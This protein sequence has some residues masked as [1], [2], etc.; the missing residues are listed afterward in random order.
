MFRVSL[1]KSMLFLS[2]LLLGS[3]FAGRLDEVARRKGFHPNAV[4]DLHA[5]K[6]R[7]RAAQSKAKPR[8]LNDNTKSKIR[9]QS[10]PFAEPELCCRILCRISS[11]GS[12]ELYDG[13]VSTLR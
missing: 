6:L 3:T 10:L 11:G 1:W 4:R 7:E 2:A 9:S 5:A 13:N 12:A 8:Y